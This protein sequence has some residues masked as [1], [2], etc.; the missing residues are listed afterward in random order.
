MKNTKV[1]NRQSESLKRKR[2]LFAVIWI[3]LTLSIVLMLT[4]FR[5]YPFIRGSLI[6]VFAVPFVA[7]LILII[8]P[9]R[10]LVISVLSFTIALAVEVSQYFKMADTL[11]LERGSFLH[12]FLGNTFS[13]HDI[14]MYFIG[15]VL[16]YLAVYWLN[17]RC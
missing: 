1:I 14:G 15:A 9:T 17:H 2:L 7:F 8:R 12:Q 3:V 13:W 16:T 11:G 5:H 6:D 4:V 10:A